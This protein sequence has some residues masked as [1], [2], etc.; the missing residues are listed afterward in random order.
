MSNPF[1]PIDV[2]E[3][4]MSEMKEHGKE[5]FPNECCGF[6][7]GKEK[8]RLRVVT[9]AKRIENVKEG[10][11]RRRFEI[12]GKD[13]LEAERFAEKNRLTLLGVYHSHPLHP[14][15]PSKYDLA[16]AM[17]WFSYIIVS[18]EPAG[19]NHIRSWQLNESRVFG[20]ENLI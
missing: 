13:Y 17:P 6:L 14:A 4:A 3:A 18:V 20:E 15:I 8:I 12:S 1:L 11:R 2:S 10:N 16:V 9:L 5:A 7:Y 19:V